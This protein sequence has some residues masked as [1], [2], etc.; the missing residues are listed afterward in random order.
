MIWVARGA[1][2]AIVSMA[3]TFKLCD[4]ANHSSAGA[5]VDS[6]VPEYY[7]SAMYAA[8]DLP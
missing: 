3:S 5:M 2:T 4:I 7:E 8:R 1:G 6:E